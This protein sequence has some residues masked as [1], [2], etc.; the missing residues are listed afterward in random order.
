MRRLTG[1]S[2]A[3]RATSGSMD[4]AS[5]SSAAMR[6][7]PTPNGCCEPSSTSCASSTSGGCARRSTAS[8]S[9]ARGSRTF[10]AE[11]GSSSP[12]RSMR[13]E[14]LDESHAAAISAAYERFYTAYPPHDRPVI[15]AHREEVAAI[16]GEC[17]AIAIAGGHVGVLNDCL[18]LCNLASL[19]D[20]QP[21]LA[22]SSG[23]M[24]IVRADRRDRR[25][26]PSLATRRALRHRDRS[27]SWSRRAA[28]VEPAPRPRRE[29]PCT[30]CGAICS[31]LVRGARSRRPPR[32]ELRASGGPRRSGDRRAGRPHGAG[33]G[34]SLIVSPAPSQPQH[35][36]TW[37][38]AGGRL[39]RGD[40]STPARACRP[41]RGGLDMHVSLAW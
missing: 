12:P 38:R 22:W 29:R 23:C 9:C 35:A 17:A 3:V 37:L 26:R 5:M 11:Q 39:T 24:A 36:L 19:I 1:A 8:T 41:A 25:R 21:L 31:E 6:S 13:C 7:T 16:V 34:G 40:R 2:A 18:H 28:D 20:A 27:R 32:I 30:A 15:N 4:G 14:T 10:P 33:G